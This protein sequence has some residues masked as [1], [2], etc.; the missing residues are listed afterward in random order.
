MEDGVHMEPGESAARPVVLEIKCARALAPILLQLMAV[1]NVQ[2]PPKQLSSVIKALVQVRK[3]TLP[4]P[5]RSKWPVSKLLLRPKHDK[6]NISS[7]SFLA[8]LLVLLCIYV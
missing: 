1:H 5:Q 3:T 6:F 4:S 8:T 2:D 7:V